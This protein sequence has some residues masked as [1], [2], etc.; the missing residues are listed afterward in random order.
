VA[1]LIDHAR[2]PLYRNAYA[3]MVSTAVSSALGILYWILAGRHYTTETVGLSSA[4]ISGMIFLSGVSQLSLMSALIRYI[5][6]AGGATGR[7]VGFAYAVAIASAAVLSLI[8]IAGSRA[9][10]GSSSV[11]NVPPGFEIWIVISTMAWSIFNLQDSVLTGLRDAVWVAVEN[12][13]FAA[14]KIVLLVLLVKT[15]PQDGIFASWMIPAAVM[16][17][18]INGLIFRRLIPRHVKTNAAYTEPVI[19]GE[20]V[21][22]IAGNFLGSLF[23]LASTRLL[24]VI[25]TEQLG[26]R[27]GAFFFLP[28]SIA[29]SLKLIVTNMAM[30]LT[31]E[32]SR[33]RKE[34]GTRMVRFLASLSAVMIPAV[35]ILFLGA[36]Y[37]LNLSGGSYAAEG[38]T[39]FRLLALSVLPAILSAVLISIARVRNQTATIA[40]GQ[41]LFCVLVLGLSAALLKPFGITGVG[42]A[43]LAGE[44]IVAAILI[45]IYFGSKYGTNA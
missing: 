41:A 45:L 44:T 7:L 38:T 35:F 8:T 24:P 5:P 4:L 29:N 21:S 27:A 20:V 43:F 3:W 1:R 31:V 2:L 42:Y 11:F 6:G 25:V 12:I 34:L 26:A 15:M 30:S 16:I 18:P 9:W 36:P 17:L 40:F 28:W 13:V 39:L 32:G 22:F 33:D 23:L 14:A 37:I 19:P 10:G